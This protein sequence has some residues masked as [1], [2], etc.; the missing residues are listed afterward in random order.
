MRRRRS[1]GA[2]GGAQGDRS[3]RRPAIAP[4]HRA[5]A[6]L[7]CVAERWERKSESESE[8]EDNQAKHT[9]LARGGRRRGRRG[10]HV[11]ARVATGSLCA[12]EPRAEAAQAGGEH[13]EGSGRSSLSLFS[14]LLFSGKQQSRGGAVWG[15]AGSCAAVD[16]A[17]QAGQREALQEAPPPPRHF[18]LSTIAPRCN[19]HRLYRASRSLVAP[20]I[21]TPGAGPSPG[22]R[23]GG[24]Q[25]SRAC[26]R[27][28]AN[29]RPR[30]LLLLLP[31]RSP[32]ARAPS[33]PT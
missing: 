21:H 18:L 15:G 24:P 11:S 25:G 33:S 19:A 16:G 22:R 17:S 31:L 4:L 14:A 27:G 1:G 7:Q 5:R 26:A 10:R 9:H 32:C 6:S 3:R 20:H 30:P 28:A 29:G 12:G 23:G 8:S 2:G 13:Q